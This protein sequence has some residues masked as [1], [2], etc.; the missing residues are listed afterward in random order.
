MGYWYWAILGLASTVIAVTPAASSSSD[1]EQ[2]M[3]NGGKQLNSDDLAK[4]FADQ[5]V[6]FVSAKGGKRFRI[7]YGKSN[8]IVGELSGG[9]WTDNGF[10]AVA[11]NDTICLSWEKSDRPRLRCLHVV[12]SEGVVSKYDATGKLSGS[13]AKFEAGNRLQT[14][15]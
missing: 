14:K 1:F 4:R 13:I 9:N 6:T 10:Y 12:V 11:D 3:A 15:R 7:Y 5:T 2:T 8:Q